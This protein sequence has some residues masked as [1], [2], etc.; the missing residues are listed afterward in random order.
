[1][2]RLV[3][4]TRGSPLAL[5]QVEIALEA[6][7]CSD[8]SV[9]F[10]TRRLRTEGDRRPKA[11]LEEIGGQGVFVK[12]I[13]SRLL[14]GDIDLAVHSLKDMP[15]TTPPGLTIGA[16]LPREDPRDALVSHDGSPLRSLRP[17]ARIGTDSRR[18]AVQLLEQRPDI[19][20]MSIRGNVDTR[21]RKVE[22]GEYDAAVLAAA[23]LARLGLLDRASQVFETD[24]I[25]PAV[26]QGIIAI[27][28]R[29]EDTAT[30]ALLGRADDAASRFAANA[31]RSFL[32]RL[33]AGCRLPVGAYAE[34]D[35]TAMTLRGLLAPDRGP[36]CRGT[37]T[38]HVK[39]AQRIGSA[40]AER[41]VAAA[42]AADAARRST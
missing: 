5:R 7:R 26:G 39:E 30:A 22:A 40:L 2:R 28:C 23:G 11:P 4:G 16:V 35:G 38:G 42:A 25:L 27:E 19:E 10:E 20:V 15:A 33:G 24:A 3:I 1:M 14:R 32:A 8:P 41:L 34:V 31:E 12:D 21:L 29:A 18:R 36:L 13:E 17:G 9:T 6:L 37:L